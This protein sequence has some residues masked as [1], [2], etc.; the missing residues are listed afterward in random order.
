MYILELYSTFI[1][2]TLPSDVTNLL[3]QANIVFHFT[4]GFRL[5]VISG[6]EL[7]N[8][9][10]SHQHY[11]LSLKCLF[12]EIH[13]ILAFRHVHVSTDIVPNIFKIFKVEVINS[14]VPIQDLSKLYYLQMAPGVE[15]SESTP[16]WNIDAL[17]S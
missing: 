2:V 17:I 14:Q 1:K 9:K 10:H 8:P 15:N 13:L 4:L 6:K 7:K 11:T 5:G 16:T 12:L 3:F